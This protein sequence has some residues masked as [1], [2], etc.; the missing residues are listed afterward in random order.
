MET[1]RRSLNEKFKEATQPVATDELNARPV[2]YT[3]NNKWEVYEPLRNK[4]SLSNI[5]I[6]E[7]HELRRIS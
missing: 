4:D 3:Y 7:R 5:D 2:S 1:L 6:H